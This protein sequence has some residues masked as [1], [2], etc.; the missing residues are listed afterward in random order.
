MS[1]AVADDIDRATAVGAFL[2]DGAFADRSEGAISLATLAGDHSNPLLTFEGTESRPH[3]RRLG[4]RVLMLAWWAAV[5]LAGGKVLVAMLIAPEYLSL[6]ASDARLPRAVSLVAFGVAGAALIAGGTRDARVRFLGAFFVFV[7]AAFSNPMMAFGASDVLRVLPLEAFLPLSLWLFVSVFPSE[8]Q[9]PRVA[10]VARPFIAASA[11][12]GGIFFAGNLWLV[13]AGPGES[14]LGA[15]ALRVLDRMSPALLY[16]P[17]LFVLVA[18]ALAHLLWKLR[19]GSVDSRQRGF[20]FVVALAL[21]ISPMLAAVIA[22]PFMPALR[23]PA[24]Q[25]VVGWALYIALLS[26]IPSTAYA[27][28][29]GRVMDVSFALRETAQHTLARAVVWTISVGALGYLLLEQFRDRSAARQMG[30]AAVLVL[31]LVGFAVLMLRERLLATVDGW[32]LRGP[33]DYA[34]ALARIEH[35]LRGARGVA[36]VGAVLTSEIERALHP[37]RTVVF[38]V[39]AERKDLCAIDGSAEPLRSDSIVVELL[40]QVKFAFH[41]DRV[42]SATFSRL[43]SPEDRRWLG[44][45]RLELMCP[46]LQSD[47]H[48]VGL[49]AIGPSRGGLPYSKQDRMFLTAICGY[50]AIQLE[51]RWLQDVADGAPASQSSVVGT[52]WHRELGAQCSVCGLIWPGNVQVCSCAAPT[53]PA[54]L[55]YVVKG[56][57]QVERLVGSGGMGVVYRATDLTLDRRVAIKTLPTVTPNRV[58]SLQREARTMASVLHP[59]LAMI[60]GAEEWRN[61]P[62]LVVEYLEGGTLAEHIRRQ[63]LVIGEIVDL[64]IVLADV[65]DR[66]HSSGI[67]HR[68]IKPSNIGYTRDG[69]VKLLDFGVATILD[70]SSSGQSTT[71]GAAIF[72]DL[73]QR[74]RPSDTLADSRGR[75]VGTPL[76]MSPEAVAGDTPTASFDLWS[77]GLTLYEAVAGRHPLSGATVAEVI[78]NVRDARVADVRELRADCPPE[79]AAI[80]GDSLSRRPSL[81]PASAGELRMRLLRVRSNLRSAS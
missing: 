33:T 43:L 12:I 51:N 18:G 78:A 55:P 44:A 66:L 23:E 58:D 21:G 25:V 52:N 67:L 48:L 9:P 42:C 79:L 64:G 30:D 14:R 15:Q 62:I 16:W 47:E 49:V 28:I 65:L 69:T 54:A 74:F 24:N 3:T 57:F 36:E 2:A 60:F 5:A 56:K 41:L 29:V 1:F 13:L 31:S 77:L 53:V 11:F 72:D 63:P 50:A 32:F 37:T 45:S 39:D 70:R 59:N 75:L 38:A 35:G 73:G 7:A 61:T 26:V 6:G 22:T 68:D 81:R 17:L 34:E 19:F 20:V 8:E 40:R 27:V 71:D 80:L 4:R 46:L 10:R 76:Y